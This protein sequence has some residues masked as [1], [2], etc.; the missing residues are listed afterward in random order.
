MLLLSSLLD[1]PPLFFHS[2]YMAT[3][4]GNK[5]PKWAT[6]VT[7]LSRLIALL[8]FILLPIAAFYYG[9]YYQQQIDKMHP[10]KIIF[11]L[12]S[13]PS[14]EVSENP[15]QSSNGKITCNTNADCP[16][17]YTCTQAGP[18]VVSEKQHK[19]CWKRGSIMP[20]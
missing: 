17:G 19:T 20:L 7:P 14:S 18:I 4:K 5:L 3:K 15:S 6:T 12:P 9:M 1:F 10:Q 16:L 2:N 11:Q 13:K 8:M